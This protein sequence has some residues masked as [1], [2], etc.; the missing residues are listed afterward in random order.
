MAP[1][2]NTRNVRL[3]QAGLLTAAELAATAPL[4]HRIEVQPSVV[5]LWSFAG[6]HYVDSIN[7]Y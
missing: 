2:L 3:Y 6:A 5:L 4:F 1:R 7:L